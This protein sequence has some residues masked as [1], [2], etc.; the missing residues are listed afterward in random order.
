MRPPAQF[1]LGY[2][3]QKPF[4]DLGLLVQLRQY[5]VGD[6]YLFCFCVHYFLTPLFFVSTSSFIRSSVLDHSSEN[7]PIHRSYI[8]LIGTALIELIRR[9]PSS[10]VL[11]RPTSRSTSMC[12]ITA[13]RVMSGNE[14]PISV[15]VLTPRRS[16]SSI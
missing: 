6:P 7:G 8:C 5:R 1:V 2:Y 11:T 14:S 3:V 13:W 15:V 12:F 10:R 9:R 4:G 16:R